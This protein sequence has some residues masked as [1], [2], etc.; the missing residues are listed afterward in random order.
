MFFSYRLAQYS[1]RIIWA[2]LEKKNGN[3]D[4]IS[5]LKNLEYTLSTARKCK[6]YLLNYFFIVIKY[7]HKC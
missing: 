7:V 4:F 5:K 3:K 1:S 6:S 2:N